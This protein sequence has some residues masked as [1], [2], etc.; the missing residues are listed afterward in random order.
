MIHKCANKE[1]NLLPQT[2]LSCISCLPLYILILMENNH[3]TFEYQQ[4]MINDYGQLVLG[5]VHLQ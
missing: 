5:S 1:N 2:C 3:V 4:G